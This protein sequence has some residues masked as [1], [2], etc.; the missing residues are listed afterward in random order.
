MV[1]GNQ[2]YGPSICLTAL[3]GSDP[4]QVNKRDT[5]V[6]GGR[7]RRSN[8]SLSTLTASFSNLSPP[9]LLVVKTGA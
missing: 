4:S 6:A 8:F 7:R 3:F 2:C 9:L 1:F 5:A